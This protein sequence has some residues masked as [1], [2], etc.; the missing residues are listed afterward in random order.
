MLALAPA[1]VPA[2]HTPGATPALIGLGATDDVVTPL[3]AKIYLD[4]LPKVGE[5]A[6]VTCEISADLD[7]EGTTATIELPPNAQLVDGELAWSGDLAASQT[8]SFSARIVFDAPGDTTLLARTRRPLGNGDSW[9]DLA[10][11]YLSVGTVTSQRGFAPIPRLL[12]DRDAG[13]E[14][15]PEGSMIEPASNRTHGEPN[16]APPAHEAILS[17]Q[18]REPPAPCPP[19]E[20]KPGTKQLPCDEQPGASIDDAIDPFA[21]PIVPNGML[22]VTGR[23]SYHDRADAY[24]PVREALVEL[25]RGDNSA[26]LAWCYTDLSGNYSCGPVNN[27]GSVGVR[28]R[29]HSW[30][31]YNPNGDT[32]AVVNPDW[33]TTNDTANT[34]R[35]RTGAVVLSDGTRDIGSWHVNNNDPYERAFWTLDDLISVWRYI[36]FNG[37]GVDAGSTTVEW[38]IDSTV[39]DHYSIDG[40]VHLRGTTPLAAKG[41][42]A[43][44]EYA[45]NIMWNIYQGWPSTPN[46]NPHIIQQTSSRGCAWTEGWAEFLPMVVNDDPRFYWPDGSSLNLESP[47][48]GS[49]GWD[50]GDDVEGRVAGALWDMFDNRNDGDD[51]YGTRQFANFWSVLKHTNSTT[52]SSWFGWWILTGQSNVGWGPVMSIYQNTIEYRNGPANDDFNNRTTISSLPYSISNLNTK[53]ATT[54]GLDPAHPC[55]SSAFPRQSRSVWYAYTPPTSGMFKITTNGSNYDTVLALWR[56][57][58][59]ALVNRGCNDDG[60]G[61]LTSALTATLYSGQTYY[62]QAS[63]YGS[64]SAG[65]ALSFQ[66]SRIGGD[67]IFSDGFTR[68]K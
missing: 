10:A 18:D 27:P 63:G 17:A 12:R 45:H 66:M 57:N 42:V 35:V 24:L 22:T 25:I 53:G 58:W 61:N 21:S 41:T 9:G 13:V 67:Y 68:D 29:M 1:L 59:G 23:W 5:V 43:K 40:N 6:V 51:T 3:H 64:S 39:G 47:T 31:R 4:R 50:Q 52:F 14:R 11:A 56:G 33:G 54:Q 20:E 32:I 48:W 2:A 65:G 16:V 46:C 8:I 15:L 28:T 26:H 7:A 34:Y 60:G 38:K 30:T 36:R 37:G 19:M 44:H 49:F 55:A 62:V